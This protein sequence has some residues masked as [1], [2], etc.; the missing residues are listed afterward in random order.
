MLKNALLTLI[1]FLGVYYICVATFTLNL[2]VD[3][4]VENM[5]IGAGVRLVLMYLFGFVAI[6]IGIKFRKDYN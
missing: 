2:E 1:S 3:C 4:G 6:G 5:P